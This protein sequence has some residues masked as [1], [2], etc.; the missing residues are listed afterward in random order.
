DINWA[1]ITLEGAPYFVR[2]LRVDAGQVLL[3]LSNDVEEPL[4]PR[5]LRSDADGALYCDVG[6]GSM[7]ARFDR[8][9]A[10]QLEAVIGED[11][12]GV[13]LEVEGERARPQVVA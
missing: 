1:Y 11:A 2:T 4:K 10:T 7:V 6:D 3:R 9:A 8:H 12:Q 5:T 13:Y